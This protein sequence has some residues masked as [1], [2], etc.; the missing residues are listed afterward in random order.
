[1]N[2]ETFERQ[3]HRVCTVTC[4]MIWN[5]Y[6]HTRTIVELCWWCMMGE[7]IMCEVA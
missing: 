1:M 6:L 2:I 4:I 5:I 7:C 3:S